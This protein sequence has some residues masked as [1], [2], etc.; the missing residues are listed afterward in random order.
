MPKLSIS[1]S[2]LLAGGLLVWLSTLGP[3][4]SYR[5]AIVNSK[6]TQ[7]V[8]V[9]GGDVRR[10]RLGLKI[11]NAINIPVVFSGGSNPEYAKWLVKKSGIPTKLAKLDYRGK[12]T[13]GTVI[14]FPFPPKNMVTLGDFANIIKK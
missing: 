12:D 14:Y 5:K 10:E 3:L 7:I 6:P 11:S 4:N 8:V 1:T 9:L 2:F 13:L